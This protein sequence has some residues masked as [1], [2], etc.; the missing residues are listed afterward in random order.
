MFAFLSRIETLHTIEP[1]QIPLK[2]PFNKQITQSVSCKPIMEGYA[3]VNICGS[4]NVLI[5]ED[6]GHKRISNIY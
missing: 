1:V 3:E 6:N 4:D 5:R 2:E